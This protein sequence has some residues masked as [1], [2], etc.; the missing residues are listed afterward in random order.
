MP[1]TPTRDPAAEDELIQTAAENLVPE[2]A[3]LADRL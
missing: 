3:K 1:D 2:L